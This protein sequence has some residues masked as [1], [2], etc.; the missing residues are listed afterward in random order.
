MVVLS[1]AKEPP[2][3][4]LKVVLDDI[5]ILSPT[6]LN[7]IR[8]PTIIDNIPYEQFAKNLFSSGHSDFSPTPPPQKLLTK[9]RAKPNTSG[10]GQMTFKDAKAQMEEIKRLA[11]LKSKIE[12]SEKRLKKV[13][14]PDEL[15]AHAEQM[16]W[17][18][19]QAWKLGIFPPPELTTFD[20]YLGEKKVGI[21]RKRR[22]EVIHEVFVKENIM[23]DGMHMNLIPLV[24]VV[25]SPGLVIVKPE[26]GIFNAINV[27]SETIQ[28][29]CNK[30]IYVIEPRE[31]VVEARKIV[32]DNLDTWAKIEQ[33]QTYSSQRR[34]QGSQR[35]L[36]DILVS[37]DGYQLRKVMVPILKVSFS[38]FQLPQKFQG[39]FDVFK[40]LLGA[41][42]SGAVSIVIWHGHIVLLKPKVKWRLDK[43]LTNSQS[44]CLSAFDFRRLNQAQ[45]KIRPGGWR[46][47]NWLDGV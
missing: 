43:R 38:N 32:Q 46:M 45:E 5:S 30:M 23:V 13:M 29:M 10:E 39:L 3:K 24:G 31:D 41:A 9:E 2:I 7:S 6:P 44:C 1:S 20:L 15:R 12:K 25:G 16:A 11:D 19:T 18:A 27:N 42:I 33:P 14:T 8:P 22:A 26:A 47:S 40:M 34:R 4:K 28:D 21:K 37:W 36:E 17:V 35:L